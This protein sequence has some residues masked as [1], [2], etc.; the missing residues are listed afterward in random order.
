MQD[1]GAHS[2]TDRRGIPSP[3]RRP[4]ASKLRQAWK[5]GR[6]SLERVWYAPLG[7]YL[8][9]LLDADPATEDPSEFFTMIFGGEAFVDW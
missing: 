5:G 3:Q 2:M 8:V 7:Y 4:A 1:C 6:C 9:F